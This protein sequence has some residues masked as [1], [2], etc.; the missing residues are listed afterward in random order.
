VAAAGSVLHHR[1]VTRAV[2]TEQDFESEGL[3]LPAD[4]LH[5]FV[6]VEDGGRIHV[7]E[8]GTGPVVLL[9][10]GFLLDSSIWAHQFRDLAHQHRVI[11]IDHRGHGKSLPGV[12]TLSIRRL[13]A[14]LAAVLEEL[15]LSKVLLVGHSMGGMVALQLALDSQTT[16][17]RQVTGM[18]LASTL[19]GPFL[20]MPGWGNLARVAAPV[21]ARAALLSGRLGVPSALLED[22]RY[23]VSRLGFG[24]DAR[25]AQVRF[26]EALHTATSSRTLAGLLP[27]LALFDLFASLGSIEEPV[28]VVVGS[29]DRLTPPRA[30]RRMAGVL[31]HAQ[32][33]ELARCGHMPM[34]ERPHEFSRMLD[35]FSA[36]TDRRS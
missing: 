25:P 10:H 32:L 2:A 36:K 18:V 11:A 22:L 8:G 26:V 4:L 21:S 31:P 23:L 16:V 17:R 35:E 5:H 6:E 34:I 19:A 33:V 28:L 7:V 12:S 27:S 30:A 9:L 1:S 24:G 3:T 15:D 13:A 29:H 20:Q 14:D